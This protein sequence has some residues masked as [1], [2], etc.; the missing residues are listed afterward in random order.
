MT[1]PTT[2]DP[3]TDAG[4]IV[5]RPD[6]VEQ[7]MFLG[8]AADEDA[9]ADQLVEGRLIGY[10]FANFYALAARPEVDAVRA[11]NLAKGRPRDQVGSLVTTP[12]RISAA[13]DWSHQLSQELDRQAVLGLMDALLALG[14]FGFRGPAADTIPAHLTQESFGTRT[15]QVITPG[16]RCPSNAFI[17]RCL[18]RIG[19]DFLF[20]TSANR[21]RH[22]SGAAEEPA[23]YRADALLAEFGSGTPLPLLRHR[24]EERARGRYPSHA[25]MSTTLLAFHRTAGHDG[26]GRVRLVVERH[27]S[28]PVE[29]VERVVRPL[30]FS[31]VL[32]PAADARL[33]QRHYPRSGSRPGEPRPL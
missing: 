26:E 28:L 3:S 22:L 33:P 14:P 8:D 27:G 16:F 25:P 30:G 17:G 4:L 24:D 31:L 13:F 9:V 29:D 20:V 10:G 6:T 11:A 21:S 2:V 32:G 7:P 1:E 19:S 12:I 15:T 23:H 18:R 5:S